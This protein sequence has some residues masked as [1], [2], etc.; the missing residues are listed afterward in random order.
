V[1]WQTT[2]G[3]ALSGVFAAF[4]VYKAVLTLKAKSGFTFSGVAAGHFRYNGATVTNPAGNGATIT[5][6]I[7]RQMPQVMT[8]YQQPF[9]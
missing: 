3:S 6:T 4:T 9:V 2:E 8:S 1:A 7:T 5:V